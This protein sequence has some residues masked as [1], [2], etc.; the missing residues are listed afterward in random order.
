MDYHSENSW[1]RLRILGFLFPQHIGKG[2]CHNGSSI[3]SKIYSW[4]FINKMMLMY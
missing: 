4:Y 3:C 2:V 1:K